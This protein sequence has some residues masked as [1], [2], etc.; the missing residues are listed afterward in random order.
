MKRVKWFD[1]KFNFDYQDN[2]FP[3]ILKRLKETPLRLS[4]SIKAIP[5]DMLSIHPDDGWSIKENIGHLTDLEPLWQLRLNDII[6]GANELSPAD[7]SNTKTKEANH[8]R[9]SAE[10][11]IYD[12]TI[13]RNQTLSMLE[14]IDE[15][16][17]FKSSLHPRLKTPMRTMDLFLFVA[18]HDDHHLTTISAIT[19]QLR[20]VV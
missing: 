15:E 8:D 1:R 12:F 4:N 3:V 14:K 19:Q 13:V 17:I 2:I 9:R 7:L 16:L 5:D 6:S 20:N 10:E 18:E 11:L